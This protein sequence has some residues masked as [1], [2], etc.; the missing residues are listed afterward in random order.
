M[1]SELSEFRKS[2]LFVLY[3]VGFIFALTSAIP[4]YINSSFLESL[5]NEQA[6]GLFYIAGSILSLISLI[7]I[8][9]ILK[10]YG[11]YKVTLLI[12]TISFLNFLGLAF[13]HNIFFISFCFIISG[14]MATIIYF[15]LDVFI[16]HNSSD[17]KTGRIRSLYLSS[18]NFAWLISPIIAG[19]IVGKSSYRMIYFVV[20]LIMLPIVLIV[21]SNL[22]NFKDPDY[23]SLN[24]FENIRG[25]LANK[26]IKNIFVSNFLL[27]L[28]YSWMVVYTPIYLN[29]HMGIDWGT[30][31]II[32]SIMLLPYILVEIP[33]GYLADIKIGEKEVLTLGFIIM[34]IFTAIIPQ[35]HTTSFVIWSI[36]LFMTR[37]GSAMVEVMNDTYFFKQINDRDLNSINFYRSAVPLS[38]IFAPII[39]TVLIFFLPLGNIFYIFGF[40]MLFG[41]RYSLAIVDTK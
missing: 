4:A 40:L 22:K 15:D 27:Q 31:G 20:A 12:T 5:T 1:E 19:V 36:V 2:T 38:Y 13:F 11:N 8:P 23:K 7:I 3:I 18:I 9:K 34:G 26:N 16:E 35:I 21:S 30:I 29:Q 24:I 37:I 41:L 14:S 10:R 39:A 28:F 32:F 33:F 17:I 25:N 6:V